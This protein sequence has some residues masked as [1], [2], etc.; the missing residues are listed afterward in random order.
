MT[1]GKKSAKDIGEMVKG[2]GC[3]VML[4]LILIPLLVLIVSIIAS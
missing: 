3:I 4:L 2:C 1:E